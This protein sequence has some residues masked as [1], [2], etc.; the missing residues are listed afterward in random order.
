MFEP[1]YKPEEA[2]GIWVYLEQQSGKLEG[3]S[4]EL[5]GR[6]RELAHEAK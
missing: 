1:L 6:A 4:L 2:H 5:L 3:V